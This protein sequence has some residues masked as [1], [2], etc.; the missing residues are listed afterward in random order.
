MYVIMGAPTTEQTR[1]REP[2]RMMEAPYAP[3]DW[4]SFLIYTE[5]WNWVLCC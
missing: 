2:F 3:Q 1:C 5:L 4:L